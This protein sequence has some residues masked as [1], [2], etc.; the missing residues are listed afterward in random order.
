[1]AGDPVHAIESVAGSDERLVV[2]LRGPLNHLR[3]A[4]TQA[5]LV[6]LL[7]QRKPTRLVMNLSEV[8]FMD[9]SGIAILLVARRRL[10]GTKGCVTLVGLQ[11][12]MQGLIKAVKLDTL[13]PM[14]DTEEAADALAH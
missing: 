5:E 9:S 10:G 12:M 14:V 7:E 13:F 3:S 1:M 11:P 2:R 6:Q 8:P 4:E